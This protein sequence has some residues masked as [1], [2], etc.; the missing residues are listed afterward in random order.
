MEPEQRTEQRRHHRTTNGEHPQD[1][2]N[3]PHN[4]GKLVKNTIQSISTCVN[5][6]VFHKTEEEGVNRAGI[7]TRPPPQQQGFLRVREC[8]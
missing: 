2:L 1:T 5:D 4:Y 7:G 6:H 8:D 3:P